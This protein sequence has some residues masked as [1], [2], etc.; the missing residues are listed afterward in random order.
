MKRGRDNIGHDAHLGGAIV[1]LL[2][3]A[4]LRPEA[5]RENPK[6]FLLALVPAIALLIYLWVNP[7]F[8]PVPAFFGRPYRAR[9]HLSQQPRHKQEASNVDAIL[10]KIAMSG[11]DSL[12]AEERA[13]LDEVSGKYQ[14]RAESKKPESGLPI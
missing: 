7:L 8:L 12:T 6:V 10:E 9:T 2:I 13:L 14:R 1:G 11:V 4:A 5:V 3:T